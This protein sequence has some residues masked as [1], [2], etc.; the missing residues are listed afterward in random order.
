[1]IAAWEFW[2]TS[3]R[4]RW[5]D[6]VGPWPGVQNRPCRGPLAERTRRNMTD[7]VELSGSNVIRIEIE[8][9][10]VAQIDE[11]LKKVDQLGIKGDA[12]DRHRRTLLEA[13]ARLED[14]DA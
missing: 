5:K 2:P 1:M 4:A 7:R 3:L 6:A 13:R 9:T 11:M 10:S 14:A 8:L 12:V